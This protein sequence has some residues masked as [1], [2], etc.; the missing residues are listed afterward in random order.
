M[1]EKKVYVLIK[2]KW[3]EEEESDV[4]ECLTDTV[5]DIDI[6]S[7]VKK[8]AIDCLN[9]LLCGYKLE[10]ITIRHDFIS[11]I[12]NNDTFFIGYINRYGEYHEYNI[13]DV[14]FPS[15]EYGSE[16]FDAYCI[17]EDGEPEGLERTFKIERI[18]FIKES[19]LEE[20]KDE[21]RE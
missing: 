18:D 16:Y 1:N 8:L 10:L 9:L 6:K 21:A 5:Y 17:N 14:L 2:S 4:S 13:T 19:D 12:S 11:M 20:N 3:D 7:D 15:N